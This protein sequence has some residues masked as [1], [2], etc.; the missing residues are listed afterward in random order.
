M[1]VAFAPT[2]TIGDIITTWVTYQAAGN[3]DSFKKRWHLAAM[4][5]EVDFLDTIWVLHK[6][7]RDGRKLTD[8]RR[9]QLAKV[10]HKTVAAIQILKETKGVAQVN[11]FVAKKEWQKYEHSVLSAGANLQAM[12][13][14]HLFHPIPLRFPPLV[15]YTNYH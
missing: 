7:F 8:E 12:R 14:D 11:Q 6:Y 15:I 5:E 4:R 10:D 9:R 2:C 3:I 13:K 1:F